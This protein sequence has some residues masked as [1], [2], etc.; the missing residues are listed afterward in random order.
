MLKIKNLCVEIKNKQI[1]KNLDLEIKKNEIH[2]IMGPNGSGKSTL[3]K[4][5]IKDP[6]FE[7]KNGEIIFNNINLKNI[8]AEECAKIGIF[9]AF[10]NP[11]EIPGISNIQFI[12]NSIKIKKDKK[13]EESNENKKKLIKK[14]KEITKEIEMKEKL[15][16]RSINQGFSGGEKKL[17]EILQMNILE[18]EIIILDE[19]DSGL[20]IDAIKRISEN[21]K[22]KFIE[23]NKTILIITHHNK[24]IK[25]IEPTYIHIMINGKI[26]HTG[27]VE[28]INE[29]EQ[30]GYNKFKNKC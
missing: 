16:Y 10:Q 27:G 29:L 30:D 3:A 25:Y 6:Q 4:T 15:L 13:E 1:L 22:K 19:I 7:I 14:I 28:I 12:K 9:L 24:I 2:V 20:D 11:P 21:I 8:E 18:P 17:N 26:A 23:K 5:I